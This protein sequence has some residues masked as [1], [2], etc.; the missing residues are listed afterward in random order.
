MKVRRR[1]A[2]LLAA[3]NG[4]EVWLWYAAVEYLFASAA[5]MLLHRDTV[6]DYSQWRGTVVLLL[7]YAAWG[8]LLGL[9]AGV[10]MEGARDVPLAEFRRRNRKLIILL[11][12]AAFALNL[13]LLP[14][15]PGKAAALIA[16]CAVAAAV[17]RDFDGLAGCPWAVAAI[18]IVTGRLAMVN[19]KNLPAALSVA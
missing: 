5:P 11:M 14:G 10:S 19:W 7:G 17:L 3:A 16:T 18:L 6:L 12:I 8:L 1:D 13:A 15:Q 4:L 2:L 9:L